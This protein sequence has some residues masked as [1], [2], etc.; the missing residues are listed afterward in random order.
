MNLKIKNR[1]SFRP[2]APVIKF[3]KLSE[4]FDLKIES[5]YMML[6]SDVKQEKRVNLHQ[7]SPENYG[8][9]RLSEI[10]SKIPAVTH[11]DYSARIQTVTMKQNP[12][13]YMLISKF[14]EITNCPLII[15]TSFNIRGEPIVCSPLQAYECF[16][17]TGI[18]YLVMENYVLDKSKQNKTRVNFYKKQYDEINLD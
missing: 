18:N 14:E 15:N 12:K 13:L 5:P 6:V 7:L 2:F 8:L 3:D 16:M 9:D 10:R 1:E 4:W 17:K 11:I